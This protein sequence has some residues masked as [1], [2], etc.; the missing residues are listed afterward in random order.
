M[1]EIFLLETIRPRALI[2]DIFDLVDLYNVCS[3]YP[4][5]A[6]NG[7]AQGGHMKCVDI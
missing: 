5:R 6:Q 1:K 7:T 2:L 3:Y 4:P